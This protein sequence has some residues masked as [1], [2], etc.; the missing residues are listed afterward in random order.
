VSTEQ[1]ENIKCQTLQNETENVKKLVNDYFSISRDPKRRY[2][3]HRFNKKYE[4]GEVIG[5]GATG[6]VHEAKEISKIFNKR[7][8]AIKIINPGIAS[9]KKKDLF[10]EEVRTY[11]ELDESAARYNILPIREADIY[12]DPKTKEKI[13]FCVMLL[14]EEAK[15]LTAYVKEK[16]DINDF[17]KLKV[18]V[19]ICEAVQYAHSNDIFHGDLKPSNILINKKGRPW[20]IDFGLAYAHNILKSKSHFGTPEYMSPEQ[21]SDYFGKPGKQSDIYT[22]GV[23]LFELLG[24]E[25]PYDLPKTEDSDYFEKIC[26]IILKS[27][28]TKLR[29]VNKNCHKKT[30][31]A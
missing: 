15:S 29:A 2:E 11:L 17:T 12:I 26:E 31:G 22:L 14:V 30:L 3:G 8:V 24:G 18:F 23:I 27:Q 10:I 7:P 6:I 20:V 28:P 9:N 1:F 16:E 5:E 19:Q 13:P 4:L 21:F 25:K